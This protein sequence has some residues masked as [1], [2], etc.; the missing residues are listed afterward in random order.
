MSYWEIKIAYF[1]LLI[2]AFV[3]CSHFQGSTEKYGLLKQAAQT[4]LYVRKPPQ[5]S[6]CS[7]SLDL[8]KWE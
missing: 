6:N 7:P 2:M 4:P 3:G 8:A 1:F 5:L